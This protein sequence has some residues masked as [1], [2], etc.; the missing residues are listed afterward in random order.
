MTNVTLFFV[1]QP[2]RSR[3]GFITTNT[4]ACTQPRLQSLSGASAGGA[5]GGPGFFSGFLLLEAET[6][7][8]QHPIFL[9]TPLLHCF[10]RLEGLLT[11]PFQGFLFLD[12]GLGLITGVKLGPSCL[13]RLRTL[14]AAFLFRGLP[15]RCPIQTDS[16]QTHCPRKPQGCL[17]TL[18]CPY[19]RPRNPSTRGCPSK[20]D[21]P[22]WQGCPGAQD[23]R[24]PPAYYP[25]HEPPRPYATPPAASSPPYG[26]RFRESWV[27]SIL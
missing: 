9:G 2:I 23:C 24:L 12:F 15:R 21:C 1:P 8:F 22:F 16:L 18:C 25:P 7:A 5:F 20:P 13:T 27:A 17:S 3:L 14:P 19:A 6:I 10:Q 26:T 11:F 4:P